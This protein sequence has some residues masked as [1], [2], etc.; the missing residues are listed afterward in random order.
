[1]ERGRPRFC[2]IV[3][4][5]L[6]VAIQRGMRRPLLRSLLFVFGLSMERSLAF[7]SVG[8]GRCAD[9][10]TDEVVAEGQQS[11]KSCATTL[12]ACCGCGPCRDWP[13]KS[14]TNRG[15]ARKP[16]V[17]RSLAGAFVRGAK[18]RG[19]RSDLSV[20][21][22]NHLPAFTSRPM[23]PKRSARQRSYSSRPQPI[24]PRTASYVVNEYDVRD[25]R[26]ILITMRDD[27]IMGRRCYGIDLD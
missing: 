12:L 15:R 16:I 2:Q 17:R 11:R 1:M 7:P 20:P 24:G 14:T 25:S 27:P 5:K 3:S 23:K 21:D 22:C 8:I 18:R 13:P 9:P 10:M 26:A 19:C 4:G 6:A